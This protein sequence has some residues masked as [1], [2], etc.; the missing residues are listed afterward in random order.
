MKLSH[1]RYDCL[2]RLL[3]VSHLERRIFDCELAKRDSQF[4]L[5]GFCLWLNCNRYD[6]LGELKTFENYGLL[7]IRE[8]IAR[9]CAPKTDGGSN[10]PGTYFLNLLT[11]VRVHPKEPSNL[12]SRALR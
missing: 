3:V 10:I 7:F 6:R 1:A 9:D 5:I 2:S 11:L 12:L 8:R 4:F